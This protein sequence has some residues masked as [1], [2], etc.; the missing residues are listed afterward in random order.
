MAVTVYRSTDASAPTLSGTV[1]DLVNVLDKCLVA[2]YGSKTAAGWSK[3]FTGTNT[4]VF[5][6]GAGNQF[7]LD[8][9]DNAA[10]GGAIANEANVRGYETMTA[11][12][13]GTGQFPTSAQIAGGIFV[14]KSSTASGTARVW[15]VIADDRT[16]YLFV[17]TADTAGQWW[18]FGFGDF[19]SYLA[20][21]DGYRTFIMGRAVTGATAANERA[22]VVTST[23]NAVA[24]HYMARTYTGLGGAVAAGK[25]GD[26]LVGAT[27]VMAGLMTV[28][29]TVDGRIW[30]APVKLVETTAIVVRGK[31]RG[32]Y[33]WMHTAASFGDQD[34]VSGTGPYVGRTFLLFKTTGNAAAYCMDVTGPW[35]GN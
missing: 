27:G 16:F 19:Y 34:T 32:F 10:L 12:A 18:C 24:G 31:M 15:T 26:A 35:D 1:G 6:Q 33:H 30:I 28:P 17:Q 21:T 2:G 8:V 4:A 13:T 22:D 9:N 3:P 20:G 7:Y 25:S 11:V 14:R 5:R 29:N 23:W